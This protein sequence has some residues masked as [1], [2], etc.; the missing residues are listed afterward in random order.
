MYVTSGGKAEGDGEALERVTKK[1][2]L[3]QERVPQRCWGNTQR[4]E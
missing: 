3:S 4:Y 2:R 1:S